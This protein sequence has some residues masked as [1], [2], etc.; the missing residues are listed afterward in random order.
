MQH[1]SE[2][3]LLTSCQ[4]GF[5]KGRSCTTNLLSALEDWTEMLDTGVHLDAIYLDFSKAFDL[6]PHERLFVKLKALG[7]NGQSIFE[8]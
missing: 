6:M 1:L 8:R 5:V 3:S 2:H 7:I 4:H